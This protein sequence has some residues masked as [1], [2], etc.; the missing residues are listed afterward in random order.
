MTAWQPHEL[1]NTFPLPLTPLLGRDREAATA[2]ELLLQGDTRLLT[3]TGPG[4]VGKTRLA[5][6]IASDLAREYPHGVWFVSLAAI[7]DVALVIP[8][9]ARTLGLVQ[10][11]DQSP[12]NQLTRFLKE[13][14]LLLVLDNV[15]QV[16]TAAGHLADLLASCPNLALL[17]TSRESLRIAGEQE[18]PVPP[19]A[20]PRLEH[21]PSVSD[22]A[23][24]D[25]IAL[26]LQRARGV[27]PDFA[28]T[29]DNALVVAELCVRLDGLPLAVELAAARV[30]VLSPQ[31][32]LARMEHRLEILSRD[33][34]D[35]PER[36]RTMRNAIAWSHDLLSPAEQRIFR[37]LS[38]FSNGAT[39]EAAEA[40]V[41]DPD[42][43]ERDLLERIASLVDKSLLRRVEQPDGNS[44][45]VMLETIR[46]FGLEQL[47]IG[48]DEV[49][50][51]R[52]LAAW[53]LD[54]VD[55]SH[56]EIWGP[57]HGQ[58]L[59]RLEA[60]HDNIRSVLNWSV[61]HGEAE[62]AQC[63]AGNLHRFWW[64]AGYLTEGRAWAER[65]LAMAQQT[66]AEARA[67]SLGAAGRMASALGDDE[68]AVA[69]MAESVTICRSIGNPHLIATALWRLGMAEEDQGAYGQAV[70]SLEEAIAL[71]Q[72]LDDRLLAA[73]ARHALGV[74]FYEQHALSRASALFSAALAE[75]RAFD[76]PWL[77]GYALAS[78][79]KI[80]RAEGDLGRA[81]A[82]YAE[83]LTL[84]WERVGDR[85]GV[86]G[87]LRG[88][89][90]IA[91]LAG[92]AERAARLYGAA[93][94]VRESIAAPLPRHHPLSE[95]AIAKARANL[96][97][98]AF[99][100]AWKAGRALS[101]ADAIA[102]ALLVPGETAATPADKPLP[103]ATRHGLT[104]REVE[105]L[106]LLREGCSNRAIGDRLFISERTAR[107][108]VQNILNKLDVSTRAAA[109]AYAVEQ[110][111]IGPRSGGESRWLERRTG[112]SA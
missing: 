62:I 9:I 53:C 69:A 101:L 91:A 112:G 98:D 56:R 11:G 49:E 87:S 105:V 66:S 18:F 64:F 5:L 111:L 68:R 29:D 33:S 27:A 17:V 16:V 80:A 44:R 31:S 55:Q 4:G 73:A 102:E 45:Y 40:V 35:V 36:L 41:S 110:G 83:S 106:G 100:A 54:L 107:T 19:L 103:P 61:E 7:S 92:F 58:W 23:Q 96:G 76:Q 34:R 108:H 57:M 6:Q 1:G 60:E 88:L 14:H 13:R 59:A 39:L 8:T 10:M 2:R 93:E 67:A 86:A 52:R 51:R 46:S 89:A 20:I 38:V 25:A 30:K 79:G 22:L 72:S 42:D 82:L 65:A 28:L 104:P 26:F 95:R 94:V 85:V 70:A 78:L 77:M 12:I 15:E 21:P 109:A 50:T 3:L 32:L 24:Y 75:F 71:F 81:A 90:S 74:V 43:G 84:R 63:L 99:L 48:G 97:E 47:R 37:R